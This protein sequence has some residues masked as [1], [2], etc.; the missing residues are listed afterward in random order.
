MG[1][2]DTTSPPAVVITG[3]SS[4]IG[5]AC[6]L[7]LS[8]LGFQVFAGVRREADADSLRREGAGRL[9]PVLL[10]VTDIDSIFDAARAI[11]GEVS[12]R[13]LAGLVN[14][15]GIVVSGPLE[16]MPLAELRRQLEVNVIG[17]VAVTEYFLPLLRFARGRIV[18]MGS[19]SGRVVTPFLGPYT[20]S[21]FAFRALN[22]T[23]RM[24][25]RR[26]GV[27]VALVEPGPVQTPLWGKS[28]SLAQEA[29]ERMPKRAHTYY[30]RAFQKAQTMAEAFGQV[31]A[32]TSVVVR[33]VEH[34]LTAKRPRVR[35]RLYHRRLMHLL[36]ARFLDW[37]IAN[38]LGL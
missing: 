16:F 2:S 15:A 26:S 13:G 24:E 34:A 9:T 23:M 38:A 20:A 14:N 35:Y 31:G 7:H 32:P 8:G 19:I 11:T 25:L 37:L 1:P 22:D 33:A 4:G 21:K 17:Q 6:A 36:P 5:R 10:E 12:G 30:G 3:A 27:Q 28:I 18:N 29:Q